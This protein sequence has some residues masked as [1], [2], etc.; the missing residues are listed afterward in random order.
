M[1]HLQVLTVVFF[2]MLSAV[3]A[4]D[5]GKAA[6][7]QAESAPSSGTIY[8][9]TDENG[10]V[11]FT[12]SRPEKGPSERVVLPRANAVPMPKAHQPDPEIVSQ[13]PEKAKRKPYQ[14][15]QITNPSSEATIRDPVE[16]VA[17]DVALEPALQADDELVVFDN[18]VR[19]DDMTLEENPDRGTHV[20]TAKVR[21]AQ[22]K[23]LIE[24]PPVK[25]FIHQTS[26]RNIRRV[27]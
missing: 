5:D 2:L 10:N 20:L 6:Q 22:G 8:R 9:T 24:S 1:K 3:A 15:L 4:G 7:V 19:L 16:P 27:P 23:I 14:T 26:V 18:G 12:D 17:I 21:N 13:E 25:V 11:I